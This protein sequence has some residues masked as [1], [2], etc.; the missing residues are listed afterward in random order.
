MG[1]ASVGRF[2]GLFRVL[3]VLLIVGV[4]SLTALAQNAQDGRAQP[5][6]DSVIAVMQRLLESQELLRENQE[7]LQCRLENQQET[8]ATLEARHGPWEPFGRDIKEV[9]KE[10][11]K[12]EYAL[13]RNSAS[14]R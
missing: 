5:E 11:V 2:L 10:A 7:L 4:I 12:Y 9:A 14:G 6:T 3:G 8:L 13:V 1:N